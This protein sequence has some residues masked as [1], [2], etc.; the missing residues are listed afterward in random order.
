M[1]RFSFLTAFLLLSAGFDVCVA[2]PADQG[3]VPA[4]KIAKALRALDEY[5]SDVKTSINCQRDGYAVAK[6]VCRDKYLYELAMLN[7]KSCVLS[8]ENATGDRLDDHKYYHTKYIKR[9]ECAPPKKKDE[10]LPPCVTKM[11]SKMTYGLIPPATCVTKKC[12]YEFYR[13]EINAS[14]GD[15]SPF[16]DQGEDVT[17][18][19]P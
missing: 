6:V 14:G 7:S 11:R 5:Y 9:H 17:K 16:V 1:L 4:Q 12:I 15:V 8:I 18:P 2:E 3:Y 10:C 19:V 13:K